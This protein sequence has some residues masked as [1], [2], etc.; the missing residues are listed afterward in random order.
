MNVPEQTN[1]K[2]RKRQH[3]LN[4]ANLDSNLGRDNC[5]FHK[6]H[7]VGNAGKMT[8]IIYANIASFVQPV[9]KIQT[10]LSS[11]AIVR[12]F[13]FKYFPLI[14]GHQDSPKLGPKA[15]KVSNN[16]LPN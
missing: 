15:N 12:M 7:K 8:D 3:I 5:V 14:K 16:F 4:I 6:Q 13:P 2:G 10:Y 1:E 9:K 11:P